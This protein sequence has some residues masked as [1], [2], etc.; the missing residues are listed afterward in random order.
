[1]GAA[2]ASPV[3]GADQAVTRRSGRAARPRSGV[4]L[5]AAPCRGAVLRTSPTSAASNRVLFTLT[6]CGSR[7]VRSV[8]S[9]V[10]PR[11][12]ACCWLARGDIVG[13]D[14][15]WPAP[16]PPEARCAGCDPARRIPGVAGS[17]LIRTCWRWCPS[18]VRD[19][20]IG[21]VGDDY[22]AKRFVCSLNFN[23]VRLSNLRR[24]S[25][26]TRIWRGGDQAANSGGR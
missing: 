2:N 4:A 16:S 23:T 20:S 10:V 1:L 7:P 12:L 17:N 25:Q 5:F 26:S 22:T 15:P 18:G 24:E 14:V 21:L 19:P 11:E 9:R 13:Y 8:P 6:S 3:R